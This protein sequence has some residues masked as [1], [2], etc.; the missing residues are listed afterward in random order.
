MD[1]VRCGFAAAQ[2]GKPMAFRR[3][4]VWSVGEAKPRRRTDSGCF[5]KA[6][7]GR[8]LPRCAAAEPHP[9]EL[10]PAKAGREGNKNRCERVSPHP[11]PLP[12]GEGDE[13]AS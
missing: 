4:P 2:C 11:N 7:P 3:V 6:E 5:G 10:S 9:E 1:R 12:K 13:I 8:A